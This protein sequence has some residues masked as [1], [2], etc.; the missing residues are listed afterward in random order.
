MKT[1]C[2]EFS[3]I[4]SLKCDD[5]EIDEIFTKSSCFVVDD[6]CEKSVSHNTLNVADAKSVDTIMNNDDL[7]SDDECHLYEKKFNQNENSDVTAFG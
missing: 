6:L 2:F 1:S 7:K 4:T 3:S 5:T